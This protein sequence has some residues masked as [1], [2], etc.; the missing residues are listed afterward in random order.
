MLPPKILPARFWN[1]SIHP[2]KCEGDVDMRWSLYHVTLALVVCA[3]AGCSDDSGIPAT[4]KKADSD[5]CATDNSTCVA[6][7]VADATC[8]RQCQLTFCDCLNK[9]SC[10]PPAE[11]K[12]N[13]NKDGS[14]L[15]KD[16]AVVPKDGAAVDH[17]LALK[18]GPIATLEGG[19]C[20]KTQTDACSTTMT[21]C[22]SACG[23]NES[24]HKTC[25]VQFCDCMEAAG[26]VVDK[27]CRN[28]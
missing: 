26:C 13:A 7:C 10:D 28:L 3:V 5:K 11:C 16:G 2:Q 25:Q 6:K 14:I 24:C 4:C 17:A 8:Q 12:V 19:A 9:A 15:L 1:G 23:V 21:S 20:T 27:D 18:D 22:S